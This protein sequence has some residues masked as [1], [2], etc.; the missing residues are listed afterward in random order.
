[1]TDAPTPRTVV[2]LPLDVTSVSAGDRHSC[3]GRADGTGMCW[4][5]NGAY[6]LGD[7]T[8][9]DSLTPVGVL[10]LTGA[11]AIFAGQRHSCALTGNTVRCWGNNNMGQ[12]GDGTT[13]NRSTASLVPSLVDA[14][15]FA[16]GTNHN[17]AIRAGGVVANWGL[18]SSGQLGT[19]SPVTSYVVTAPLIP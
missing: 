6:R 19:G 8:T 2:G 17:L 5:F 12:M 10:G 4:G 3:V 9:N 1:M 16:A 15:G 14:V 13:I 11:S 18:G 7:G